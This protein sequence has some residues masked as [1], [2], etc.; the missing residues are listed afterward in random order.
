[1]CEQ[2]YVMEV[3]LFKRSISQRQD[4]PLF[5]VKCRALQRL[6]SNSVCRDR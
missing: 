4:P 5:H 1:M 2:V 3:I 6:Y